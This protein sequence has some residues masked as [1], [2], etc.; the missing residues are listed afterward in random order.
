MFPKTRSCLEHFEFKSFPQL[1]GAD[2]PEV[3]KKAREEQDGKKRRER[4][5]NKRENVKYYRYG[6]IYAYIS[7][8]VGTRHSIQAHHSRLSINLASNRVAL[9]DYVSHLLPLLLAQPRSEK[10]IIR[11]ASAAPSCPA[12]TADSATHSAGL[13]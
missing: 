8:A 7:N 5:K 9:H 12:S 4:K 13:C 1:P 10:L 11:L 6:C 2:A 3:A